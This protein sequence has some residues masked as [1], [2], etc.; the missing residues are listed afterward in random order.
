[1][2]YLSLDQYES[3]KETLCTFRVDFKEVETNSRKYLQIGGNRYYLKNG[4]E[5]RARLSYHELGLINRVSK[6]IKKA[7]DNLPTPLPELSHQVNYSMY[8]MGLESYESTDIYEV[9]IKAA[10][11]SAAKKRG[12]LSDELYNK[13]FELETDKKREAYKMPLD[14]DHSDTC[15]GC[16]SGKHIK[17]IHA[18]QYICKDTG[19]ALLHSKQ[20]RL[21]SLGVLAQR[22]KITEYS[23]IWETR[24]VSKDNGLGIK[25]LH[26]SL[27]RSVPIR[28][29][30]EYN[31][32]HS[33]MFYRLALDIDEVMYRVIT[34]VAGVY[35]CWTDAIFC[36][37]VS[38]EGVCMLL[39]SMGY[40]YRVLKH[41]SITFNSRPLGFH[42]DKG[43]KVSPYPFRRAKH[44]DNIRV[45]ED[46]CKRMEGI[47]SGYND[48][49]SKM[50]LMGENYELEKIAQHME[51]TPQKLNKELK[52][53]GYKRPL[54]YAFFLDSSELLGLNSP[55]QFNMDYLA[56]FL[57][58]RGLD[59]SDFYKVVK[60]FDIKIEYNSTGLEFFNV[61]ASFVYAYD[62]SKFSFRKTT[63][64]DEIGDYTE[65]WQ[66][67]DSSTFFSI[68]ND[69]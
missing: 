67:S 30:E 60:T 20:C 31:H 4:G 68:W 58:N 35:F 14:C 46:T 36:R 62:E 18:N 24:T 34:E 50:D 69:E 55:Q 15:E 59:I 37:G 47:V 5:D 19:A 41:N 63:G 1:M 54:D 52:K 9:D 25:E 6:H 45:I 57:N 66:E 65:H 40:E 8:N 48:L 13:F 10:Y 51:I 44:V 12:V 64:A 38:V 43:G 39:D 56:K 26:E 7:T 28:T 27:E 32:N 3:K 61:A 17:S 42:I 2:N 49:R 29:Y 11:L 22:K 33:N 21:I 23:A 53:G 16:K